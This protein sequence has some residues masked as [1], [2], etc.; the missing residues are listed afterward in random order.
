RVGQT[1]VLVATRVLSIESDLEHARR[2]ADA[3]A[4]TDVKGRNE[5]ARYIQSRLNRYYRDGDADQA[6]RRDLLDLMRRL[7]E[8]ARTIELEQLPPLP[9]GADAHIEAGRRLKALG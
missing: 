2:R 3:L 6:E 7:E 9:G 1:Y 4:A 8:E 5:L